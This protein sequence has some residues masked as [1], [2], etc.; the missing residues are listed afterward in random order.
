[1]TERFEALRAE[2]LAALAAAGDPQAIQDVKARYLGR[3]GA[4]SAL[5][6]EIGALPPDVRAQVGQIANRVKA[7]LEAAIDARALAAQRE[8]EDAE[9]AR[10]AVDVTLPGRRTKPGHRHPIA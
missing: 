2:A 6:K 9:L 7:E 5:L 4:I 8:R 1:M 10:A 3:K